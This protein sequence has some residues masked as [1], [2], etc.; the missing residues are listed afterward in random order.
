MK[1]FLHNSIDDT[2]A[3]EI[4]NLTRRFGADSVAICAFGLE[5]KSFVDET[6]S[7]MNLGMGLS[8]LSV[9]DHIKQAVSLH[10]PVFGK[11]LQTT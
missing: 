9:V 8:H 5:G 6:M 7:F 1:E 11:L 4:Q 2:E 3:V 10:A